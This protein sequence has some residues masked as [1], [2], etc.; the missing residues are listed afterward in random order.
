[1]E[2]V[3]GAVLTV[4]IGWLLVTSYLPSLPGPRIDALI[5]F[6]LV[7]A[8]SFVSSFLR[9]RLGR[10]SSAPAGSGFRGPGIGI[11]RSS[12]PVAVRVA[13]LA[14]IC[15][16]PAVFGASIISGEREGLRL[17]GKNTASGITTWDG[18][19][20]LSRSE[21]AREGMTV[22]Q[23]TRRAVLFDRGLLGLAFTGSVSL[24]G[25]ALIRRPD[26]LDAP[27]R[28]SPDLGR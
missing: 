12:L 14:M 1:V 15:A 16:G 2:A 23:C 21:L 9:K 17:L 18:R 28:L 10:P 3:A 20:C 7:A 25:G 13:L 8:L 11:W 24:Y 22:A 6:L 27:Q 26:P 5:L 19:T 4:L